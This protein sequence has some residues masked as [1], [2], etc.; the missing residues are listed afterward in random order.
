M[1]VEL[2]VPTQR[3]AIE[4]MAPP[5]P[6]LEQVRLLGRDLGLLSIPREDIVQTQ[7]A[8]SEIGVKGLLCRERS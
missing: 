4:V 3:E 6:A 5:S 1:D 8:I 7:G 2:S